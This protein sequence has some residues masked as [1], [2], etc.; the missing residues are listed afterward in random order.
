M[1]SESCNGQDSCDADESHFKEKE[2]RHVP[3]SQLDDCYTYEG[4]VDSTLLK[5]LKGVNPDNFWDD[6][7]SQPS[8][9]TG[10]TCNPNNNNDDDTFTKDACSPPPQYHL[11]LS[12]GQVKH[13][14][15]AYQLK[16]QFG[17]QKL[18]DFGLLSQL[19]TGISLVN[20]RSEK[21]LTVDELVN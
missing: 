14:V 2:S 19:G 10:N 20:N 18:H 3:E 15:T 11:E 9:T 4:Q 7:G 5:A 13:R 16:S 8:P 1:D 12:L 6:P 17:G 21:I